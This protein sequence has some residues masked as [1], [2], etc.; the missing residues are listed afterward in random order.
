MN[1]QK[2]G[3]DLVTA[4]KR[5]PE[6]AAERQRI[7]SQIQI[8][9]Q[10]INDAGWLQVDTV[11][12][13]HAPDGLRVIIYPDSHSPFEHP[14]VLR[15]IFDFAEWYGPHLAFDVGDFMEF[16]ELSRFPKNAKEGRPYD[17][18]AGA[19]SGQRQLRAKMKAGR[20]ALLVVTPGNHDDRERRYLSDV[21]PLFGN[22]VNSNNHNRLS[23]LA[24]NILNFSAADPIM[25][26]WGTGQ[27]GGKD[28]GLMLQDYRIRH[29]NMVDS[30]P[31]YSAYKHLLK[32]L[33]N[34]GIGH[35]H[36]AGNVVFETSE[37]LVK[38]AEEF[39]CTINW[40][41]PGFN[42]VGPDHDWTHSFGVAEVYNGI[43]HVQVIP[44]LIG[45][46]EHGHR[47]EYFT[48]LDSQFNIVE[49]PV[50]E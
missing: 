12:R 4:F 9:G 32:A 45:E 49:F 11:T 50:Y 34:I 28:G 48:Y 8:N 33:D 13:F 35:V 1:S 17:M 46:D 39:G 5:F 15:A 44:A 7:I 43:V 38:H 24:T 19:E 37:G 42:Y 31:A 25:F 27:T 18:A 2:I 36:R 10:H 16:G 23:D 20:P 21:A 47:R 30:K 29:G 22:L 3:A 26:C 6:T 14:G 41:A 40:D